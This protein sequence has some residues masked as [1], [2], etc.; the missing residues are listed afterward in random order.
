MNMKLAVLVLGYNHRDMLPELFESLSAQSYSDYQ[1]IYIDNGSIDDST[2]YVAENFPLVQIIANSQNLGYAK[3]YDI[4]IRDSFSQGFDAVVLLN[5]DT[6]VHVDWLSELVK[7][8]YASDDIAIAQSKVLK[9]DSGKTDI[10]NT[11]GNK[12]HFLGFGYCGHYN[13]QDTV[14]HDCEVTYASGASQLLKREYYPSIIS[15]DCDYF[16]YLEDQDLGWQARISGLRSI[17]SAKSKVWHRYDFQKKNLNN[18]KFYLLERNR[19]YFLMKFWSLR[20]ILL[21]APAFLIMEVGV[22]LQSIVNGYAPKKIKAYFHF[23]KAIKH[24]LQKRSIIQKNR[25]VPDNKLICFLTATIDFDE[26]DSVVL[27]MVNKFLKRYYLILEK[28][29]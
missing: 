23:I 4:V 6:V 25:V 7:S 12:I 19:L 10:I 21:I 27:R 11:F 29:I 28:L 22:F 8:A 14:V 16:A 2:S 9:W 17:A 15:F 24:L 26:V 1:T 20:M 13:E 5:P 3:A 18:F